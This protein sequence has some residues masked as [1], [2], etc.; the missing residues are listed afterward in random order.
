MDWNPYEAATILETQWLRSR[1]SARSGRLPTSE[2]RGEAAV[3]PLG[4]ELGAEVPERGPRGAQLELAGIG[5][6]ARQLRFREQLARASRLVRHLGIE[7]Q[8]MSP[9]EQLRRFGGI[10]RSD[11]RCTAGVGGVRGERR[12]AKALRGLVELA[13]S[14]PC[15]VDVPIGERYFNTRR[16]KRRTR[17]CIE[18]RVL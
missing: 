14:R 6:A 3:D 15:S 9:L 18:S 16:E 5:L 12:G 17:Q 2:E 13:G 11:R 8:A 10:A 1:A 4:V 7:P